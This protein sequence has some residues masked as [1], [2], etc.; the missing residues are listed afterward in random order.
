M[1]GGAL[2]SF[3]LVPLV[4]GLAGCADA[5]VQPVEIGTDEIEALSDRRVPGSSD[6]PASGLTEIDGPEGVPQLELRAGDVRITH[7]DGP[8][9]VEK[10]GSDLL[11]PTR[12]TTDSLG[13]VV[14]WRPGVSP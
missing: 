7:P 10:L 1:S 4:L 14:E 2:R 8:V 3:T 13:Q 9:E 12:F 11:V 6:D 5:G